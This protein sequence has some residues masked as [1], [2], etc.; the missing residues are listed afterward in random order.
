VGEANNAKKQTPMAVIKAFEQ[1]KG[2]VM[3]YF[4]EKVLGNFKPSTTARQKAKRVDTRDDREGNDKN[5]LAAIRKCVCTVCNKVGG[6]DP[7]HLK[8]GT[9]ERGAGLRSTD[10]WA[11]PLCRVHHNEVE[12]LASTREPEWFRSYGIPA[13]LDLAA[14]LWKASPDVAVMTKIILAHR[15]KA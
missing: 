7:H 12:R 9:G 6:N 14:A 3:P 5:H 13:P 10:K 8:A 1:A 15:G 11:V 2:V 4:G